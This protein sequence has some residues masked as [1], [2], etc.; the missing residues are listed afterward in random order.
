VLL[1]EWK[2]QR[3]LFVGDAEWDGAYKEGTKG[4]CSWNVMWNLRKKGLDGPVAFYKIGHHGSVNATPWGPTPATS[5]PEPVAILNAILPVGSKAKATAGVS[6]RRATYETIP[7]SDLLAEIGKRVSNTR[8]YSTAFK[9]ANVKTSGV[10]KFGKF[11]SASFGKAQPR[12]TDLEGMLAT[13]GF[14]D[15]E[16]DP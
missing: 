13:Q 8:T 7:R 6:T 1:I 16:L 4:N 15:V 14:I 9:Q 5:K 11:E 2:E 3:L 10:P 12:R